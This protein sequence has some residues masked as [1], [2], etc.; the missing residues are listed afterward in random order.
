MVDSPPGRATAS[1]PS[2]SAGAKGRRLLEPGGDLF[3]DL[4]VGAAHEDADL[5][6]A[7]QVLR[8]RLEAAHEEVADGDVRTGGAGQHLLEPGEQLGVGRGVEDVH[9]APD[10]GTGGA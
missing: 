7:R 9:R 8:H 1:T 10:L 5:Q 2:R 6:Q 3:E 4:L